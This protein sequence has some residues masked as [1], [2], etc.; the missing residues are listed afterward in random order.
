MNY[1]GWLGLS[2]AGFG[3]K[4]GAFGISKALEELDKPYLF[5]LHTFWRA[6]IAAI[7][8]EKEIAVKLIQESL[9]QGIRHN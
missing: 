3:D 5:G 1:L 6:R 7:L 2:R 8:G 9:T 4:E